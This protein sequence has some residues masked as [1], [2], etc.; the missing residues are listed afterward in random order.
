MAQEH[1]KKAYE[2]WGYSDYEA[3]ERMAGLAVSLGAEGG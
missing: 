2:E 3:A 1:M